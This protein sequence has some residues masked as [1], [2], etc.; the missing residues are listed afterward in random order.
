[1]SIEKINN[2]AE[3]MISDLNVN[4]LFFAKNVMDI[5]Q[6]RDELIAAVIEDSLYL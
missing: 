1:M 3:E 2:M 4:D 5:V 6:W